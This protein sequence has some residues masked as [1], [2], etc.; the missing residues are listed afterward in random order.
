VFQSFNLIKRMS[1]AENVALPLIYVA[2][3]MPRRWNWSA[4][5]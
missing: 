2:R 1:V 5:A 4:W 3:R